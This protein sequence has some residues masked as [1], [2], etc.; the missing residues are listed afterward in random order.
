MALAATVI[1][2]LSHTLQAAPTAA[3]LRKDLG[4]AGPPSPLAPIV[5]RLGPDNWTAVGT[6]VDLSEPGMPGID[7]PGVE[8]LAA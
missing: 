8:L 7:A 5:Q 3:E 1:L 2:F 4:L 6:R